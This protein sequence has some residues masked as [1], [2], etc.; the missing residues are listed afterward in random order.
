MKREI[1]ALTLFT[2]AS[3][4]GGKNQEPPP[5]IKKISAA[6]EVLRVSNVW[7]SVKP[8]K[9]ILSPPSKIS[10]FRGSRSSEIHLT[11][12]SATEKLVIEEEL[13]LRDGG[14][15]RCRTV[16]EHP[17]STRWGH[18]AGEPA[19]ELIRPALSGARS[20]DG[21]HPEGGISEPPLRALMVLRSDQLVVIEPLVD[22]RKYFPTQ[23]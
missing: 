14:T 23:L 7:T 8:N 13:E 4:C 11:E 16:F 1:F 2:L 6:D 17:L 21:M 10:L 18:K 3:A 12:T 15:V 19:V 20:C 22:Q 5:P 9:G